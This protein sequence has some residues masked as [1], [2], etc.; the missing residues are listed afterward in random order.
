MKTDMT[1]EAIKTMFD[2]SVMAEESHTLEDLNKLKEF[3]S[4]EI[5]KFA[6]DGMNK[7]DE[8]D[9]FDGKRYDSSG[10]YE[11]PTGKGF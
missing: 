11:I 9:N 4:D 3:I 6:N 10:G 8:Q 5:I 2:I 7:L 1:I